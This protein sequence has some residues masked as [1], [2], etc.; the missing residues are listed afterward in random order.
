MSLT[1][2]ALCIGA[3]ILVASSH[4]HAAPAPRTSRAFA[5]TSGPAYYAIV[6]ADLDASIR[7]YE[8]FMGMRRISRASGRAEIVCLTNDVMM[9]E[10]I[11]F[12]DRASTDTLLLDQRALGLTK[13]GVWVDSA[14]F[15]ATK[16]KLE[17]QGAT[18]VGREFVDTQ[19][20]A[21]SFIVK[22]NAGTLIQFFTTVR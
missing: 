18:F 15:T 22:D 12:A 20:R 17:E 4:G 5:P 2:R 9:V 19:I 16:S 7:W 14:T 3:A 1:L 21:R 13:A 10:L 6:V 11:H 8:R